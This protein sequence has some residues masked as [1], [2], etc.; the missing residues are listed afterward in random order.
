[1]QIHMS[2]VKTFSE[3]EQGDKGGMRHFSME[4]TWSADS[5]GV[6]ILSCIGDAKNG[7]AE[8]RLTGRLPSED[9]RLAPLPAVFHWIGS[10]ERAPRAVAR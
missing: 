7:E 10:I 5:D 6:H 2:W 3:Y 9:G 4:K 1:M 8:V